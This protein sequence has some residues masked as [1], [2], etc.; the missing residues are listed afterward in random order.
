MDRPRSLCR[1][2]ARAWA[3]CGVAAWASAHSGI[4]AVALTGPSAPGGQQFTGLL[5]P[6]QLSQTGSVAFLGYATGGACGPAACLGVWR[7]NTLVAKVGDAAPGT[8]AGTTFKTME[9]L[10]IASTGQV[11][12]VAQVEPRFAGTRLT[13]V[14]RDA[15]LMALVG[16]PAP[17]LGVG[18]NFSGLTSLRMNDAGQ[19]VFIGELAGPDIVGL[20]NNLGFWVDGSVAARRGAPV[21]GASV[22]VSFLQMDAPRLTPSGQVVFRAS[23]QG[24]SITGKTNAGVWRG[25]AKMAR[26]GDPAPGTSGIAFASFYADPEVAGDHVAYGADLE[27]LASSSDRS[28]LWVDDRLV[29]RTGSAAPGAG[30]RKFGGFYRFY[31]YRVNT[32]GQV[33]YQAC[34]TAKASCDANTGV[35]GIWRD[36]TLIVLPGPALPGSTASVNGVTV[37]GLNAVG[38]VAFYAANV[39]LQTGLYI[40]DGASIQKVALTGDALLGS[41][42]KSIAVADDAASTV[43]N[44]KGQLAFAATLAD[45]RQGIFVYSP[46][47]GLSD[48]ERVFNWA[49]AVY[50]QFF[51]MPGV[52]GFYE[53][54]SYRYY[55]ATGNYLATAGGRVVVHNGRDW[56][57]LDVG[58]LADFLALAASAGY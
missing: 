3:C 5:Y 31:N 39:N 4:V 28:G 27:A 44:D 36:Q 8:A 55:A 25:G 42:I 26:A 45:G 46:D 14:W 52:V 21:P 53:P 16:S 51:P 7:N 20:K 12:F 57:L 34:V 29:V 32:A 54:Y 6:P 9:Q 23:L 17:G 33:V 43:F 48:A 49:E 37:L 1:S 47:S 40:S 11:A 19:V 15:T 58:A 13:G 2:F 24:T 10:R 35:D 56:N 50:P 22:D 18:V 38:Q 30:S 41:T